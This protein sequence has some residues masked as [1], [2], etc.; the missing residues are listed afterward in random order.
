MMM[1]NMKGWILLS[2][3]LFVLLM[4]QTAC[5]QL[6]NNSAVITP[7][8]GNSP[9]MFLKTSSG[10]LVYT[11]VNG[12]WIPG[13]GYATLR[14][15]TTNQVVGNYTTTVDQQGV[16]GTW[17][18]LNSAGDFAESGDSASIVKGRVVTSAFV[19]A[20]SLP[21]QLLEAAS[22]DNDGAAASVSYIQKY[23]IV[24]GIPPPKEKCSTSYNSV[25]VKF[26]A[27]FSLWTQ[28]P[29]PASVP[30]NLAVAGRVAEG[31]FGKGNIAYKYNGSGWE[32]SSKVATLYGIPG[33]P[34]LG[35]FT[36]TNN[37]QCWNIW[38]PNGLL[39]YGIRS[40][41]EVLVAAN[42]FPWSLSK[43]TSA[44]GPL[45]SMGPFSHV[46]TTSTRGGVPPILSSINKPAQ[47]ATKTVPFSAIFWFIIS[48]P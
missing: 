38:N 10:Y 8:A 37:V 18:M 9:K 40:S 36:V 4:T 3:S 11:C 39:L 34:A 46:Q 20:G 26:K 29:L 30:G 35:N 42:A 16:I 17:T 43:V 28:D 32:D 19:G 22:H 24:G 5:G 14:D 44:S 7:P 45:M 6:Y 41:P 33:T 31:F 48:S 25:T 47:G 2:C 15:K 1:A 23:N 13:N 27:E 12:A 21:Q